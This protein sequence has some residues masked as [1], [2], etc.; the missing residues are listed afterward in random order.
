[1]QTA[2]VS[3]A[4]VIHALHLLRLTAS[5]SVTNRKCRVKKLIIVM[6]GTAL[7]PIAMGNGR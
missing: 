5:G 3:S 4:D 1:M 2:C 6:S 7:M